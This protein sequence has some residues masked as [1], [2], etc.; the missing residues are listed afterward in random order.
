MQAIQP[1]NFPG[2]R[3]A[4]I[5]PQNGDR[6]IRVSRQMDN[7]RQLMCASVSISGTDVL[8]RRLFLAGHP[9]DGVLCRNKDVAASRRLRRCR[10]SA[11]RKLCD[12]RDLLLLGTPAVHH[13]G[14]SLVQITSPHITGL[15]LPGLSN[16]RATGSMHRVACSQRPCSESA[17]DPSCS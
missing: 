15:H 5:A 2:W 8:T 12:E 9:W 1:G 16:A 6:M 17:T 11:L 7:P 3:H 14:T 4:E 10:H 13:P